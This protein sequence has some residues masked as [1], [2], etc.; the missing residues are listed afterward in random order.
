L[1]SEI[2]MVINCWLYVFFFF[3]VALVGM[4][5]PSTIL[6]NPIG[7]ILSHRI[8]VQRLLY[9]DLLIG[10]YCSTAK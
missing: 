9:S 6:K 8:S 10:C 2:I 1:S 4:K 3:T 5:A 7:P